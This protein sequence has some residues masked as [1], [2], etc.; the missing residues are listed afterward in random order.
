MG[1]MVVSHKNGEKYN[2]FLEKI[3]VGINQVNFMKGCI[4]ETIMYQINDKLY[5]F[6]LA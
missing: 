2:I 4:S 5:E 1:T 6:K 3:V